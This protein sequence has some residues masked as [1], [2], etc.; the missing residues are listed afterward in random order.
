MS[1]HTTLLLIVVFLCVSASLVEAKRDRQTKF[2]KKAKPTGQEVE[3]EITHSP[4]VCKKRSSVGQKL[5][6]HYTGMLENGTVFDSSL[7]RGQPFEF[8]LGAGQV[9]RGWDVGLVDM[10]VGEKR[11]LKI[12]PHM[13]YGTRGYP[14]V[15]PP[16]A[17]LL[18]ETELIGISKAP[19][20]GA[21]QPP[22]AN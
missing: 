16:S 1:R 6:I 18:F 4:D 19:A 7:F 11:K 10:C 21:Q 5:K 8:V 12:P 22:E 17:T 14:P 15:I 9:I 3:I 13:G 2:Q 20:G